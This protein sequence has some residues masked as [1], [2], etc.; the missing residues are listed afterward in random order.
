MVPIDALR[1]RLGGS[2]AKSVAAL[3]SGLLFVALFFVQ[4]ISFIRANAPTYDE[5]MHLAAGYSYLATGDFRLDSEHPPFIKQLQAL[6]LFVGYELSFSSDTES[7]RERGDYLLGQEFLYRAKVPADQLLGLSRLVNLFLG[8]LLIVLIGWWAYRL[9]G[10][11][12]A[13]LAMTLGCLEP[14]LIA[15]SSLVT[16]DVGVTLFIFLSIYLLWEYMARSRWWLLAVT[17][18]SVGLALAS[19]FSALLVI[20]IIGLIVVAIA[21]LRG[22]ERSV[23]PLKTDPNRPPR[24]CLHAAMVLFVIFLVA[25]LVIPTMYFF[26]G[27]EPWI[28]GLRRFRSLADAGRPAF[29]LGEY[30]YQGWWTYYIVAFLIKTPIGILLLIA[31]SLIFY[32]RGKPLEGHQAIFLLLPVIV[33]LLAMTQSKV[34]IGLRHI[35]PVY[36]F[37][38]VLAAR[39]ATVPFQHRWMRR[40][41]IGAPIVLTAVSALRIAPHQLAYFNELVGGPE[42]GYRYLSDSNL[43][44]GQDLKG[45]KAYMDKEKLPII[46][47]SYFGSAPPAYYGI[48]Y[49]YVPGTW[50]LEW[51][52]PGDMVPPIAPRKILAVSVNNLQD[53]F[54]SYEPLFRWLW[55][56]QPVAKIGYSIFIYDLTDDREGLAKLEETYVKS[57][58]G[59]RA[60]LSLLGS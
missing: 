56:R 11:G 40:V 43:D 5:A 8:G 33:I 24:K 6:P 57:G 20:P 16:T 55:A 22:G 48:R 14:N 59:K 53:V 7:W 45:V 28:S 32:R 17:G 52:P 26:Q 39:L 12:T 51:P 4:G 27:Y 49:Q 10:C 19:K 29:F 23:L 34:N 42:Q 60:D 46:Y 35:L 18:L 31:G 15:H 54:T 38:I 21:S 1:M 3:G 9:W 25:L 44:W 47:L 13:L 58:M 50:P 41:L 37:L 36:P 2:S 30:S